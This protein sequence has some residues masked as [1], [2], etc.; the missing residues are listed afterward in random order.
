MKKIWVIL[1]PVILCQ[2]IPL[3]AE[4]KDVLFNSLKQEL[5]YYFS[6]LSRDSV[7]VCTMSLNALEE[8][9]VIVTSDRGYATE[10]KKSFRRLKPDISFAGMDVSEQFNP[11]SL[12]EVNF[13]DYNS[14]IFD[15]PL[16]D[17]SVSIKEVIWDALCRKYN[18][19]RSA[20]KSESKW[21]AGKKTLCLTDDGEKHYETPLTGQY[22][23]SMKWRTLLNGITRQKRGRT[24]TKCR[25]SIEYQKQ[26]KYIIK[27][28]GTEVVQ[29][30]I[31]YWI[32]LKASAFD[33]RNVECPLN[34]EYLAY[35][36]SELPDKNELQEAME[37]L[38]ARAEALS[39]ASMAEAYCGPVLFSGSA[40]GVLFHEVIGH[41]LEKDN[42]DFALMRGKGIIPDEIS[43]EYA[44]TIK[45]Y[46]NQPLNGY[47]QYDDEGKAARNVVCLKNGILKCFL[48]D[49]LFLNGKCVSSGHRRA[50][51]GSSPIPRQSNLFVGASHHY[52][53]DQLRNMLIQALKQANMEYGY[54]IHSVESGW[55][56]GGGRDRISSFNVFPTETYRVYADGRPDSLVRGVSIIGTPLSVLE[57]VVASG[58]KM[59]VFN[60][61][62]G[63]KS[64]WIP[65][66]V[67]SPMLYVSMIETQSV[68][69]KQSDKFDF[70]NLTIGITDEVTNKDVDSVIFKAMTDEIKHSM[71]NLRHSDD[72]PPFF[73]D[74]AIRRQASATIESSLGSCK[75]FE[76]MGLKNKGLV[77][78]LSGD[79]MR[80]TY[81]GSDRGQPFDLPDDISYCHMREELWKHSKRQFV[82]SGRKSQFNDVSRQQ[83]FIDDSIP[84]WPKFPSK[85]IV[86]DS[87]LK[88]WQSDALY[89]KHIA[90]TLSAVFRSYPDLFR[91]RVRIEQNYADVYRTTSD[92]LVL[93]SPIKKIFIRIYADVATHDGKSL[94]ESEHLHSY[95]VEDL[96]PV[97]SL[98]ETTIRFAE[99]VRQRAIAVDANE[100]NYIGPVL[101]VNSDAEDAL[102]EEYVGHTNI[103]NFIYCGLN[104]GSRRYSDSYKKVGSKVV[105]DEINVRQLGTD[106]I[107]KGHR[108]FRYQRFDADGIPPK[109]VELIRNGILLNQLAGRIPSP[110]V[111]KSTGNERLLESWNETGS[112]ISRFSCGT[113]RISFNKAK[114][115]KFLTKK[116]IKRAKT[117]GLEY[118][119]I[120]QGRGRVSRVN[121]K[122]GCKEEIRL[123]CFDRPTRL[124]LMGDILA[125]KEER[126]NYYRSVIHPR[127]LFFPLMDLH[128]EDVEYSSYCDRFVNLRH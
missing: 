83:A 40:S 118:A 33:E 56:T 120:L 16:S 30:R 89:M 52:G 53:E 91:T 18:G 74:Y 119:Y 103:F 42:S 85:K 73:L 79:S 70:S 115:E 68:P 96:P 57:H 31:T 9:D 111:L 108:L 76:S 113:I 65:V 94:S 104:L 106:S 99:H 26:R 5:A 60:G 12:S 50:V 13:N 97:D 7:A 27:S 4:E 44:P 72:S 1:L 6:V 36:E 81:N 62:C 11:Y 87:A 109:S 127:L 22:F 92:G 93:R 47:Y 14:S 24:S 45:T 34:K 75:Q 78:V 15:L 102:L 10:E 105:N 101:Y 100:R 8:E 39:K 59:E 2:T 20:L 25:A 19:K 54:Y 77:M 63:A 123:A 126:V 28:D 61:R 38:V 86:E 116:L 35:D 82:R 67:V 29:N 107:Y 58:G 3:R 69:Y 51:F 46:N 49:S 90:D 21:V 117:L 71:D 43:I 95:D 112:Y 48:S 110:K 84:E 98:I 125:S 17:D 64:G 128:F 88:N 66:S 41:R 114:S 32:V 80:T 55:T 122:T 121:I 37:N 124:Q 23:D